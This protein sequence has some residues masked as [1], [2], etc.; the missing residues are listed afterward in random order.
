MGVTRGA[1]PA[2]RPEPVRADRLHLLAALDKDSTDSDVLTAAIQHAA[3]E[4]HGLGAMAYLRARSKAWDLQL[5]ASVGLPQAFVQLWSNVF[6]GHPVAPALAVREGRATY[7]PTAEAPEPMRGRRPVVLTTAAILTA[8]GMA[9]VPL[10]GKEGPVGALCV[11]T[12]PDDEPAP[13][14]WAFLEEV[15]RWAAGRLRLSPLS[16]EGLAPPLLQRPE[17]GQEGEAALAGTWRWDLRTGSLTVSEGAFDAIGVDRKHLDGRIETWSSLIH[18]QDLPWVTEAGDRA[19]RTR[20]VQDCEYRVRRADG[21][22]GWVRTRG[23]VVTDENGEP[24]RMDGTTWNTSET[25]PALE[26]VGRALLHMSDGFL[27]MSGDWRIGFVN[28]AA[29]SLLGPSEDIV[30]R[31][32]WEVPSLRNATGVEDRCR[33]AV[34]EGESQ[35]FEAPGPE[36][37]RWFHLRLVPVPD[38]LT[39]YVADITEERRRE[40]ERKAAER[41]AAERAALVGELTRALAE[42]VTAQDVVTAVADSVLPAIGAS[43]LLVADLEN[44]RPRIVG[45][46]GHSRAFLDRLLGTRVVTA[47][48]AEVL[49]TREPMFTESAAVFTAEHPKLAHLVAAGGKEAWVILP[50]IASGRPIGSS[51]ISFDHPRQF[52]EDERTLLTAL[53]SLVAQ[54]LERAG[55]YDEA[56]TRARELQRALLP[57]VLPS[58]P[59]LTAAARYLPAGAD[60]EVGGD[61]YDIL[62]LS[63]ERVALVVGDVMGHGMSEA[64]TMG[65]LRTAARTLSELELPPEDILAHLNDIVAELSDE[66]FATCLYGVYDSVTG[67]FSY[68]S[69]GHPPPATAHPDGT[70]TYPGTLPN[71][72]LGIAAPPYDTV[73]THLPDGGL[74]ALFT[75]GLVESRARDIEA[76]MAQLA[77]LLG[78]GR[79][80]DLDALCDIV[81]ARLLPSRDRTSDDAA[82]LIARTTRLPSEAVSD[83][84]LPDDSTAAGEARVH[85]RHQLRAWGLG[86]DVE[87]TTEL[88]VSELVGNVVRHAKG[89]IGLRLLRSR[90]LICEVSDGSLTTPHIRHTSTADEGGR[91]LQLI[92]TMADRWGTRYTGTGKCIWTEQFLTETPP[93]TP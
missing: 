54:A 74:L 44:E 75:D 42:A 23:Q 81:T 66:R 70:V 46:V 51:A 52:S 30:G 8:A 71:P 26:S 62:P 17:R 34:A 33:A 49:R 48:T 38:G 92:A 53:S 11:V 12:P 41:A 19:I 72:P 47:S 10:P 32:L 93:R 89:P 56:I 63:S 88:L 79:P 40:A 45:A 43:G 24:V 60:T 28:A 18:P 9:A 13:A 50:L 78:P 22:Y 2:E 25:H 76:G 3:V 15:A 69:A 85:V 68:A 90:S 31:P 55:L 82:L 59:A 77:G 73:E 37:D 86:P 35:S 67:R 16:P 21:T 61:W 87:M 36:G 91:G 64:A 27:S 5:L 83:C 84:P 80:D 57:R 29:E 39:V 6:E 58:L 1:D 7:L 4:L 20:G 65:R 14:Q